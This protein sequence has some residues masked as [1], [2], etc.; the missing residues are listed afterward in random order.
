[1]TEQSTAV[2][3]RDDAQQAVERRPQ[4]VLSVFGS[5]SFREQ[6][7]TALPAHI[8]VDSMMRIALTE[9]RKQPELEKCTVPSFMGALLTA[10]QLGLRPG[11]NGEG[12]LIPRWNKNLGSLEAQFQPGYRG[13]AQLAYRSGE[14]V[15]ITAE[16]VYAADH[17]RYTL[18]SSPHIEHVPD[19]EAEH[20]DADIRAFYAV[21][22]LK[23]GGHIMKV[24]RRADA[25]EVRDRFGPHNRQGQ[26]VG[27]WATDYAAMGC[28]TAVLRALKFAPLESE[29]LNAAI[30]AE[31]DALFGDRV[32]AGAVDRAKPVAERVAERIG[33]AVDEETGEVVEGE[34]AEEAAPATE[35]AFSG[36]LGA[37]ETTEPLEPSA[38]GMDAQAFAE[39]TAERSP[40]ER[41][42][43]ELAAE[44]AAKARAK[45]EAQTATRKQVSMLYTQ[46]TA[47]SV[48]DEQ[49]DAYLKE[50]VGVSG[51]EQVPRARVSEVV[52]WLKGE[53]TA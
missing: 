4:N 14:V 40:S 53:V 23:S 17:F 45:A 43:S 24:L 3:T 15:D 25:D 50:T 5:A 35:T 29:R 18:G 9:V 11:Y 16:P 2:A 38:P 44:V 47:N 13:L 31:E 19:M 49:R 34:A 1:M 48:S 12:W 10:A 39:S 22:R 52:A 26:T 7:A 46:Q 6:V 8:G 41:S 51:F 21:I 20:R 33:V 28:K 37:D 30:K 36:D 42:P 32:A 27:P